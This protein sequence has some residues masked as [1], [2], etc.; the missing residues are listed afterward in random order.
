M[1][2]GRS[3]FCLGRRSG[4]ALTVCA[5]TGRR[6]FMMEIDTLYT[7]IIV[8]RWDQFTGQ[9]AERIAAAEETTHAEG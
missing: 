1:F 9:K 7:D 2:S 8:Q 3:G 4:S 5:Q 6:C